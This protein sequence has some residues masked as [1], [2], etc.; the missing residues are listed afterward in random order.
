M[1]DSTLDLAL[2][3][4]YWEPKERGIDPPVSLLSWLIRNP[5]KLRPAH[6]VS[7]DRCL[8]FERDPE[9][10]QRALMLLRSQ[11]E[12][13]AWYILEGPTYP[14]VMLEARD[15]IVVIEGK[16]TEPGPTIETTWLVGRHQIWRHIDGAW[17]IRGRRRVYGFFIVDG[18]EGTSRVP[19]NWQQAA[20]DALKV[21]ALE[22]SFPHRS[23][24]EREEIASCLLGVTT[25]QA[26][27]GH[28]GIDYSALPDR[29]G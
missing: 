6:S 25:W 12:T 20:A 17:E 18:V 9:T 10:V 26:I 23:H 13:R 24:A 11:Y 16:R 3:A 14:D 22:A 15:A 8:L 5:E 2:L 19:S 1:V 28:F 27:C 4:G 7:P 21:Q 29:S